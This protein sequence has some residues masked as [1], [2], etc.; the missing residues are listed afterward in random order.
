MVT[1]IRRYVLLVA[2][3]LVMTGAAGAAHVHG[4]DGGTAPLDSHSHSTC[5][6]CVHA[7]NTPEPAIGV[8]VVSPVA[9]LLFQ[10]APGLPARPAAALRSPSRGRAPPR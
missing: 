10:V 2:T 9:P 3:L 8:S 1:L 7:G 6:Y 5:A 4:S